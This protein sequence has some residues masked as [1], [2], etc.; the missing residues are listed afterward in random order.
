MNEIRTILMGVDL[1]PGGALTE[2]CRTA[3][4]YALQIV[5]NTGADAVLV[6]STPRDEYWSPFKRG[7]VIVSEGV[8]DPARQG[9]EALAAEFRAAGARCDVVFSEE[10]PFIAIAREAQKRN[11][12]LVIAGKHNR[13]EHDAKKLGNVARR[14]LHTCPCRVLV[15]NAD[16]PSGPGIILA[17]TDLAPVGA[18]AVRFAA[19]LA[20]QRGAELHVVHAYQISMEEQIDPTSEDEGGYEACHERHRSAARH[21]IAA[22]LA[23]TGF[24][25]RAKVHVGFGPPDTVVLEAVATIKPD[26]VAMGT[27]SRGG[28]AGFLTGNTAER[29][30]DKIPCSILAVKPDDFESPVKP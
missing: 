21:A 17:A 23:G 22:E 16:P 18:E 14:I 20:G 1:L 26:L 15:V 3:A 6:H 29:L 27:I 19:W 30:L 4:D 7:L 2:G 11:V 9:L 13:Y 28:I 25:D 5:K 12:D 10:K 8:A 24:E